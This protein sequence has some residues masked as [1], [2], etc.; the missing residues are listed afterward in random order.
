MFGSYDFE[1]VAEFL[2]ICLYCF[3]KIKYSN[4]MVVGA[5]SFAGKRYMNGVIIRTIVT[6]TH[7]GWEC[8][9]W[10]LAELYRDEMK[11]N[12]RYDI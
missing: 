11:W 1:D 12:I 6:R 2:D 4:S 3:L 7:C 10:L 5:G 8:R 9:V